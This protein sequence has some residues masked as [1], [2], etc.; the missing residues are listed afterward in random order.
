MNCIK[1]SICLIFISQPLFSQ[2]KLQV[3]LNGD[4]SVDLVSEGKGYRFEVYD[5]N[6][7]VKVLRHTDF[8]KNG[9]AKLSPCGDLVIKLRLDIRSAAHYA[10]LEY[11]LSCEDIGNLKRYEFSSHFNPKRNVNSQSVNGFTPVGDDFFPVLEADEEH[12][13]LLKRYLQ[14]FGLNELQIELWKAPTLETFGEQKELIELD[15]E[16]MVHVNLFYNPEYLADLSG[17]INQ[18]ELKIILLHEIGHIMVGHSSGAKQ[19]YD[20]DKFAGRWVRKM[21]AHISDEVFYAAV[22]SLLANYELEEGYPTKLE[23]MTAFKDGWKD[24]DVLIKVA[25]ERQNQRFLDQL[26]S[27]EKMPA[28]QSQTAISSLEMLSSD[29]I[30]QLLLNKRYLMLAKRSFYLNDYIKG[31]TYLNTYLFRHPNDIDAL[32]LKMQEGSKNK[33]ASAMKEAINRINSIESLS[34]VFKAEMLYFT[35]R[36]MFIERQYEEALRNCLQSI[37]LDPTNTLAKFLVIE[38]KLK[39]ERVDFFPMMTFLIETIDSEKKQIT[40]DSRLEKAGV[41]YKSLVAKAENYFTTFASANTESLKVLYENYLKFDAQLSDNSLR[42]IANKYASNG[43]LRS[44]ILVMNQ[45]KTLFKNDFELY[46]EALIKSGTSEAQIVRWLETQTNLSYYEHS[47][48][49][50]QMVT[51]Y[52]DNR[53]GLLDPKIT[54]QVE[55]FYLVHKESKKLKRA[56]GIQ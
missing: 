5:G 21:E 7:P 51:D 1:L 34:S 30:N 38:A 2:S 42:L 10:P 54:T 47:N 52:N 24:E 14:S 37:Q 44:S 50:N 55:F 3:I 29:G 27:I 23:R 6:N 22:D 9:L 20:A 45:M 49:I 13:V 43:D 17:R 46:G 12:K 35:A 53:K 39:L 25:A 15:G 41:L 26:T 40:H 18:T 4:E 28:D 11:T 31:R 56:Y 48:F 16:P 36:N 8:V 32:L 33:D 19:E